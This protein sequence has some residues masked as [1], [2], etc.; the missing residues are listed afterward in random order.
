MAKKEKK[1][2]RRK[3]K[4]NMLSCVGY[5]YKLLW[6]MRRSIVLAG[7]VT[8]P[9]ALASAA[10]SLYMPPAIIRAIGSKGSFS[11]VA[12]VI[13]GLILAGLVVNM[14]GAIQNWWNDN[15]E[16]YV[17]YDMQYIFMKKIRGM[18]W[19][20]N[21]DPDVMIKNRRASTALS[22]HTSG[23]HFPMKFAGMAADILKFL[24][25]GSVISM[26]NPL[27]VALLAAGCL[28]NSQMSKWEGRKNWSEHDKY[29][30]INKK[31]NYLSFDVTHDF[32][33]AK[34]IRL[35]TMEDALH[36]RFKMHV[37]ER[38][39]EDKKRNRRAILVAAV[40]YLVVLVRDIA[41]YAFL[42]H[43]A[44]KGEIDAASFTLYFTAI[45]S[46]S[47]LMGG[48]LGTINYVRDGALQVSDLREMFEVEN[49]LNC[50]EGIALPTKP[51]SIEFKNVSYKYPEGEKKVL[52]GI[53]FKI[54]AGEKIALVGL[55]GAGKTTLTQ[56]FCG[57]L[58]PDEGEVLLDGH[59]L[60]DYNR[61]E[62]YS[63]FGYVPQEY[64]ILPISIARNIACAVS[65]DE[66]DREKL[67]RCIDMAGL[68]D[69][70]DSLKLG[71]DTPINR[72]IN[73]DGIEMS[74]GEYQRLL[75]ARMLYKSPL[76][77]IL[78]EPT[79]AL[80]PIAEDRLY[81]RY[82][83][84]ADN[85]TSVFISHRLAS[86]KFCDR[87]FLLDGASFAEVGTHDE[88]MAL[89]GKYKELFDIQSRY[90]REE[91]QKDEE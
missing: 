58:I 9:V 68:R 53:S 41:A 85:A 71:A 21:I 15:A 4:Y 3:P 28:L 47:G 27:I 12:L 65:D 38:C 42:I 19:Y 32:K 57:M 1:D 24:L 63:L 91:V 70:V 14:T 40:S 76:C 20:L 77:M 67:D 74:G 45:T 55:N 13:L 72:I 26:L 36:E 54:A 16:H 37:G 89:G 39:A 64:N 2:A 31:I 34:E 75:L 18:D 86:T 61:D 87:I 79:A 60:T 73:A 69:K 5:I 62:M 88:L 43:K 22:S 44:V 50:G 33:P 83:E 7:L 6:G 78:D 11:E 56:M 52:D 30:A 80:D 48:L 66:I 17:F 35:Y 59:P 49:K 84:I 25:F 46:M 8:V 29:D 90:Y 23:L 82:N 81:R 51:F 10:I